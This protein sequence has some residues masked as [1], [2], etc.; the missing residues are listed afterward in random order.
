M[1]KLIKQAQDEEQTEQMPDDEQAEG[2]APEGTAA[3]ERAE[4]P[5]EAQREAAAGEDDS[6]DVNKDDAAQGDEQTLEGVTADDAP[7]LKQIEEQLIAKIQPGDRDAVERLVTAGMQ[8][9][10][11]PQMQQR[12][13]QAIDGVPPEKLGGEVAMLIGALMSILEHQIKGPFPMQA[14][15]PGG[16]LLAC[17]AIDILI[18]SGR[19]EP[20]RKMIGETLQQVLAVLVSKVQKGQQ[21]AQQQQGAPDAAGRAPDMRPGPGQ[22]PAQV[23]SAPAAPGGG[24][25]GMAQQQGV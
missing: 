25:I 22:G 19:M 12:I 3:E 5:E 9:I 16:V 6:E 10:T 1:A 4:V 21:K 17:Q 23:G 14:L 8:V 7:E 11:A 15:V 2:E 18:K 20:D 13:R 24:L